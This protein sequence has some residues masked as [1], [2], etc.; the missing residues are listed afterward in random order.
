VETS[1][2]EKEEEKEDE[3]GEKRHR[4]SRRRRRN[5]LSSHSAGNSLLHSS[6]RKLRQMFNTHHLYF[7][8]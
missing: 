1:L 8:N 2:E 7:H 3:V 6:V 5:Q 4:R